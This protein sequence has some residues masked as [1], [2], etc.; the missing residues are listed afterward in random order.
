VRRTRIGPGTRAGGGGGGG[1]AAVALE[2]RH[3]RALGRDADLARLSAPLAGEPLEVRSNDGTVLHAEIFGRSYGH[4]VVLA[5]GWTEQLSFWGP[6]IERLSRRDLR[7]VAYDLRGHGASRPAASGDYSLDRFGDDVEAVLAATLGDGQRATLVGHSLGAMSIAAW[8][9]R[10]DVQARASAAVLVNTG[11]GDLIS[12]HRLFGELAARWLNNPWAGRTV[13][14][15]RA[16]LPGLSSPLAHAIIRHAAFGP[17][18][19]A[20]EVAFYERMLMDCPARVRAAC[21]QAMFEMDLWEAA[22][23]LTV[24][25]LVI[26]GTSDRLTPPAHARRIA[27]A[28]PQLAGLL[29]LP[30][31]GHMSPLE[32][33]DEIA[34]AVA[35]LV[36]E[37]QA[38]GA[39]V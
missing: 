25:T 30:D 24:P 27:E 7:L 15:S 4:T 26:T 11:L 13:A 35:E 2:R 5:H 6:I 23:R 21:A 3:L 8:A 38:A 36:S 34:R 14:G 22:T 17:S 32:R 16:P 37:T 19:T 12:G 33:P 10:H 39:P 28:L 29:E 31:T 1:A 9:R 20:G 18:A